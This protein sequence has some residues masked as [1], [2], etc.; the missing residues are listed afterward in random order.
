MNLLIDATYYLNLS[1]IAY[2][3]REAIRAVFSNGIS[4]GLEN[5]NSL[6]LD[7]QINASFALSAAAGYPSLGPLDLVWN[8]PW[9]ERLALHGNAIVTAANFGYI[10][11]LRVLF[12]K[13]PFW[14]LRTALQA[15][16][17]AFY[18]AAR[19]TLHDYSVSDR[20]SKLEFSGQ[21]HPTDELPALCAAASRG[22]VDEMDAIIKRKRCYDPSRF[23]NLALRMAFKNGHEMAA[24]YLLSLWNVEVKIPK[25]D[26]HYQCYQFLDDYIKMKFSGETHEHTDF[27][28]NVCLGHIDCIN[29]DIETGDIDPSFDYYKPLKYALAF[30]QERA[31]EVLLPYAAAATLTDV[32]EILM[33]ALQTQCNSFLNAALRKFID[34]PAL[35]L[36]KLLLCACENGHTVLVKALLDSGK[37]RADFSNQA[38]FRMAARNGHATTVRAILSYPEADPYRYQNYGVADL[39]EYCVLPPLILN[40]PYRNVPPV[41]D[42]S[43]VDRW[44]KRGGEDPDL[45]RLMCHAYFPLEKIPMSQE[46]IKKYRSIPESLLVDP[47]ACTVLELELRV[48]CAASSKQW[49]Q[50]RKL[51]IQYLKSETHQEDFLCT[52]DYIVCLAMLNGEFSTIIPIFRALAGDHESSEAI[53]E[54]N[55]IRFLF[56]SY[57]SF[58]LLRVMTPE[59]PVDLVRAVFFA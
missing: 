51:L 24:R 48:R 36:S 28:H 35:D 54:F 45:Y 12:A 19:L 23:N 40:F 21:L 50:L 43:R 37:I 58:K 29:E 46:R 16:E 33:L 11:T 27:L 30:G 34:M 2:M 38:P 15:R 31:A 1:P 56:E 4:D 13:T 44:V 26:D 39:L 53:K 25:N 10:D 22:D 7:L 47:E 59:L 14:P 8:H 42:W 41:T 3:Q 5:L 18:Q 6:F 49:P 20:H 17:N 32:E 52:L 55:S 9:V 57:E